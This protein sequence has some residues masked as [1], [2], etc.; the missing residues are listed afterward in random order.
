MGTDLQTEG[1]GIKFRPRAAVPA[2]LG[3]IGGVRVKILRISYS[4]P[5][6]YGI[7][8]TLG[9]RVRISSEILL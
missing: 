8:R 9:V 3:Q 2:N 6:I 5:W 1:D 4:D 7:D